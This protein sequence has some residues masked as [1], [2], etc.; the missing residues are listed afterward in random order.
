MMD[1]FPLASLILEGKV[2]FVETF[3]GTVGLMQRYLEYNVS[4]NLGSC[5][6]IVALPR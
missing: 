5:L 4:R 2:L 3:P 6:K 1:C